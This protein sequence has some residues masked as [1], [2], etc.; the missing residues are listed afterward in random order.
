MQDCSSSAV[1]VNLQALNWKSA[2]G[3]F[4]MHC[5]SPRV[6]TAAYSSIDHIQYLEAA[7]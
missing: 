4:S 3:T 2:V 1:S 5:I 7:S 6:L